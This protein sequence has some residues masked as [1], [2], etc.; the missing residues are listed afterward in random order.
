MNIKSIQDIL[1]LVEKPSRYLGTEINCIKKDKNK[2]KLS[3]ALV[4]P[5]LYEIGTSHLGLHIL[6]HI[7]N[8]HEEIAAERV[9]VPGTDMEAYLRSSDIPLMSLE[10][11]KP[12]KDFDIIGFSLLYELNYTNIL[13]ILDLAKIPFFSSKRDSSYPLIIAGGP[14][15]CNPEPVAD[16]F[17]AIVI[18]DGEDVIMGISSSWL[19]WKEGANK[20][21]DN[22]YKMWADIQGVYIPSF[23]E[24]TFDKSGFQ[25]LQPRFSKHRE[26]KRAIV[27]DLDKAHFPDTPILPYGRPIHDRLRLEISRGCTR[28]C[29]FCQAGMIYRPV[30]E[31]SV[32]TIL[33]LSKKSIMATG[34]EDISL[35]S[36][37]VGDYICINSLMEQIMSFCEPR[38]IAVSFPS[39]RAGTLTPKLMQHVKRV[40]KTGFTIAPEA[41]S[42]RLRDV[43]NKNIRK[44]D[45][46]DTVKNAYDL[47]WQVIKL[48]FMVGLPTETSEDLTSIVNLV[49]E[50]REVN[51]GKGRKNKINVSVTTFIPKPHTPFQWVRQISLAESKDRVGWLQKNLKM[52]GI[53]FKWQN[54]EVSL[55]EGLWARGDRRLSRLLV[56]AH[57]KGCKLDGWSD[58]FNYRLWQEAICDEGVDIDF[59]TARSRNTE[60]PLPWDHIDVGV[61]K[62]Y[63]IEEWER[64]TSGILTPDCRTGNCNACGVCDFKFIEP[65]VFE[66]QD[67]VSAFDFANNVL[68]SNGKSD[69]NNSVFKTLKISFSK[70]DQAKYFGHLE[71]VNIFLRATRRADIPIKFSQGFHPKP[72]ISFEDTLPIGLESLNEHFYLIVSENFELRSIVKSLNKQLPEGLSVNDCQIVSTKTAHN[73]EKK[74]NYIVTIKEEFFDKKELENFLQSPEFIV[75]RIDRKGRLKKIDLK[76]MV[77]AI[78][79][80]KPDKLQMILRSESGKTARPLEV[81]K[82]IFKLTDEK[83]KKARFI[84]MQ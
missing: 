12:L 42:Q 53:N 33:A 20:E 6:Y 63:L 66:K 35:L 38:H 45:V 75:S 80:L 81:I 11:K 1:P 18:G 71:M 5:D 83:A 31:R 79:L 49:K 69:T 60:E 16:F 26:I 67:K 70:V 76:Y 84:K 27:A 56:A 78:E 21:K 46:I 4:F 36:L 72:K 58:K 55:L 14:C 40:R 37:S 9:F 24:P 28:G 62:D 74:Y 25:I 59:Y 48:Y 68:I 10:S 3:I 34:Y 2:I 13:N 29:R 64:A 30:R 47:G 57:S 43:I 82:E 51:S 54:P 19:K 61:K 8:S 65:K 44:K 52:S 73:N 7:L 15:A 50:L 41:G 17:D 22:L 39:I 23:F 77:L 32:D